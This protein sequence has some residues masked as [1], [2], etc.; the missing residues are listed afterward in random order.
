[1]ASAI[2]VVKVGGSLYDLPDLS[3]RMCRW[4]SE[5]CAGNRVVVVP[6]GGP[7]VD[8][9]RHLDRR[10]GLGEET[11]HWLALRALALNAHFLASLLPSACV[12]GDVAELY[13]AWDK[14]FLPVLDVHEFARDDERHLDRLPHSW[15]VSSD[16][17]AARVAVVLRASRLILLK[18]TAIPTDLDWREAGRLGLVDQLFA[19]VLCDAPADL[20]VRSE[21]LRTLHPATTSNPR[22]GA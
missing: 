5:Q 4:I 14:A 9:I 10:H 16:A 11:S 2:A 22:A 3:L 19:E 8:G 20:R 6:G 15:L 12:I 13:H 7:L 1:M 18:S 17:L 21:N